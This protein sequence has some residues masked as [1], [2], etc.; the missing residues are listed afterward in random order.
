VGALIN[1]T[2]FKAALNEAMRLAT[3]AN[4]YLND[5]EPWASVK[6]DP[7]RAGTVLYVSLRAVDSLKVLFSPFLP[8]SSQRLHHL[9][10]YEGEFT[11]R[12]SFES[13]AESDDNVH[14]ILTGDYATLE[15]RWAPSGLPSGQSIPEPKPLFKKLE[16]DAVV[17]EELERMERTAAPAA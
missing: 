1:E 2:R 16:A 7:A 12:L 14:E 5:E 13:V 8:F 15:G 17:A 6:S 10:G 3:L 9:L 4:R 11:G